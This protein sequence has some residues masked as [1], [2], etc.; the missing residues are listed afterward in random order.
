MFFLIH[1]LTSDV[2]PH[3]LSDNPPHTYDADIVGDIVGPSA[4]NTVDNH[5]TPTNTEHQELQFIRF[6]TKRYYVDCK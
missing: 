1:Y 5:N 6:V 3:T 2:L 4:D